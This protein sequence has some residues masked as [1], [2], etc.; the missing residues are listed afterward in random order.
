MILY[1]YLK[2]ISLTF[3]SHSTISLIDLKSKYIFYILHLTYTYIHI[4]IKR[5]GGYSRA[6]CINA[7][8]FK[9]SFSTYG[10]FF[11]YFLLGVIEKNTLCVHTCWRACMPVCIGKIF[12]INFACLSD[13]LSVCQ[14]LCPLSVTLRVSK[15]SQKVQKK[16]KKKILENV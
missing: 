9:N 10:V 16:R 2:R 3:T 6:V 15:N 13:C 8:V 14:A 11:G 4:S 7:D 1:V 5:K 12:D